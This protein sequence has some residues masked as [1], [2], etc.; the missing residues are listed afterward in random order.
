[1]NA[2]PT[3][4]RPKVAIGLPVYNGATY[5][6]DALDGILAQ[7]FT[8]FEVLI[9]DNGSVDDTEAIC[10]DYATRDARIRYVR[11]PEN[12][13]A[14][15]NFNYV[16]HHTSAPYFRWAAHDDIMDVD[17]LSDCM[18]AFDAD[19]GDGVL[20]YPRTMRIDAQGQRLGLFLDPA[21]AYDLNPAQRL[22]ALIA[23]EDPKMSL[24]IMCFPVFGLVR[25]DILEKTSLIANFP[26]SD[27]LLIV[28]LALWGRWISI[29]APHFLRREHDQGSVISAEKAATG[30]ERERLLA[31]WFDPARKGRFPATR[32]RLALGYIAAT[33]KP[34][35]PLAMRLKC[36]RIALG[37]FGRHARL[38][39]GEVR[40]L[41]TEW[42]RRKLP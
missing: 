34:P 21:L 25:R 2:E 38:I 3:A 16:F 18:A 41:V 36:L 40:I 23:P 9:S 14:A 30:L 15:H 20:A 7:R 33:L 42:M 19:S 28:E 24:A 22:A 26:R 5:L 10:R 37:W 32:T 39:R 8:D 35:M 17:Y 6:R 31:E 27:T 29:E 13:G 12:L 4:K 1:M 11:Q